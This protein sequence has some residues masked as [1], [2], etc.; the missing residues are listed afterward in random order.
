[1]RFVDILVQYVLK[2]LHFKKQ[3]ADFRRNS[4]SYKIFYLNRKYKI[5]TTFKR[6]LC[7]IT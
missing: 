1:M 6:S 4:L 3:Y 7:S 2:V 5:C